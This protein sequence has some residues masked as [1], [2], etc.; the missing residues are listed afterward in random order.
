MENKTPIQEAL[1]FIE[2]C[3]KKNKDRN[4]F[5]AGEVRAYENTKT[6]LE[7]LLPKEKEFVGKCFDSAVKI[8][9]DNVHWDKDEQCKETDYSMIE[10]EKTGFLNQLYHKS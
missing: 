7:S 8:G 10:K 3:I 6:V 2:A 1:D 5:E 4:D 9:E